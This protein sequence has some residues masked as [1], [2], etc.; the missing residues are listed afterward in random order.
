MFRFGTGS[1]D[2]RHLVG[3]VS[4]KAGVG[5]VCKNAMVL[6]PGLTDGFMVMAYTEHLS[7]E[8]LKR[9]YSLVQVNLG[10][11]FMQFGISS[12][13][14]DSEELAKL[15]PVLKEKFKFE[16]IILL[17]H[18]TGAQDSLYFLQ[19]RDEASLVNGIVLQ[20]AVSDRECMGTYEQTPRCL[21][22]ARRLESE[23]KLSAILSETVDGAPITAERFLSL[24]G[25][26]TDDDMFSTD[27]TSQEL[28]PILSAVRVPVLLCFSAEDEFV[29]DKEAQKAFAERMVTTLKGSSQTPVVELKYLTGDHGLTKPE[30]YWP[31]IRAVCDFV[32]SF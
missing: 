20:A 23:G 28:E 6:I 26:L 5:G 9:D 4:S 14:K 25:R 31:F 19:Y 22:E 10:S 32:S 16:K 2:D 15:M 27:L 29:P 17:G 11:S 24:V 8:L 1:N 3:F 18:S 21:E 7:S 12:L 30:Y 13:K